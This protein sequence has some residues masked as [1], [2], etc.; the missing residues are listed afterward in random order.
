[1]KNIMMIFSS[2]FSTRTCLLRL[3]IPSI[4]KTYNEVIF[5]TFTCVLK[6]CD[7]SKI[8][9]QSTMN[10]VHGMTTKRAEIPTKNFPGKI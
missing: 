3:N 4:A 5:R 7:I 8:E 1:M 2:R 9:N 10:G 6:T